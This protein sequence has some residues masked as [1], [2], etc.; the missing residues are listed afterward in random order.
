MF[1]CILEFILIFVYGVNMAGTKL[2]TLLKKVIQLLNYR[3][4][5]YLPPKDKITES[6]IFQLCVY[7]CLHYEC[8]FCSSQKMVSGVPEDCGVN[9]WWL[10]AAWQ[11]FWES[12]SGSLPQQCVLY[13]AISPD[14]M[15]RGFGFGLLSQCLRH[16]NLKEVLKSGNASPPT[17]LFFCLSLCVCIYAV[18]IHPP[19]HYFIHTHDILWGTRERGIR[20]LIFIFQDFFR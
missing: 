20:V 11:A 9:R 10:W 6:L 12:N 7:V 3:R 15:G 4:D 1:K 19:L 8:C 13:G 2:G 14:I 5:V 18:S 16:H 17:L